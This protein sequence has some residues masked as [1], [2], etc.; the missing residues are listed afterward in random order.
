M[1]QEALPPCNWS[2]PTSNHYD[3]IIPPIKGEAHLNSGHSSMVS[4]SGNIVRGLDVVSSGK[5]ASTRCSDR[6]NL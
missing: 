1:P 2:V 3:V 4:L 5:G 6:F